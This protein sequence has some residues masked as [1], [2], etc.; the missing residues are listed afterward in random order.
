MHKKLEQSVHKSMEFVDGIVEETT[1]SKHTHTEGTVLVCF[2]C[3]LTT[4]EL[5]LNLLPFFC[6]LAAADSWHHCFS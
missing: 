3:L 2:A 4:D 1:K 6:S 5:Q